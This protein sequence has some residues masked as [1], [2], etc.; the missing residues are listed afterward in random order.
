MTTLHWDGSGEHL[1]ETGVDRGVLF[2]PDVSGDYTTGFAWNGLTTVTESP[3]GAEATKL[4]ADNIIYLTLL[5][6]EEFG[7]TIEAFT[8]PVEFGVCDGTASPEVGAYVGQQPRS[9]FGMCYRTKIGD[10]LNPEKGYKLH[11]VYGAKASPSEKAYATVNDSPE[12]I[13]FSWQFWTTPVSFDPDG[14][15]AALKPTSY[16][17]IDSTLV[18]PADL[19]ELEAFLYGTVGTDPSLPDPDAV[20]AIFAGAL[21]QVT[22]GTPTY[23]SGTDL[24]TIPGTTGVQYKINGVNVAAGTHA[25]T[26]SVMVTAVPLATYKFPAVVTDEWAITFA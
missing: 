4:Y 10:E 26:A 12:G 1:Y 23:D 5:S 8:Y 21:T 22:P 15:Y 2:I 6:L 16:I 14:D 9:S 19:A 24:V 3:S 25:I 11:M 18:A 17:C 13:N 7:G 20:L